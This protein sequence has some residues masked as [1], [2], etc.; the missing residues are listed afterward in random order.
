MVT[1]ELVQ[2]HDPEYEAVWTSA[3][4]IYREEL[5]VEPI[6]F[7]PT[8]VA[9]FDNKVPVGSAGLWKGEEKESFLTERF[10]ESEGIDTTKVFPRYEFLPR[11]RIAEACC[12]SVAL[13]YRRHYTPL[14]L[15]QLWAYTHAIG[16]KFLFA[17]LAANLHR[18]F[19]YLNTERIDLCSPDINKY[20]AAPEERERW[21]QIYFRVLKPKCCLIDV[22]QA[23]SAFQ[24][25]QRENLHLLPDFNL[26]ER[27]TA[28]FDTQVLVS[29][30]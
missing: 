15:S 27:I 20:D 2:H 9:L 24:S 1:I 26:G 12:F 16:I 6:S 22:Q 14:L 21:E 5:G 17:T 7:P 25:K 23:F 18:S 4:R 10:C 28:V 13:P 3:Q 11:E 30:S 29:T 19:R 8:F